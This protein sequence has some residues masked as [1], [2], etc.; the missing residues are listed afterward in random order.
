MSNRYSYHYSSFQGEKRA[1]N[2]PHS[3]KKEED[4][5]SNIVFI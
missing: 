4:F 5:D 3:E 2:S 1:L